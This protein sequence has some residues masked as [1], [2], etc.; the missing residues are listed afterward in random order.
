MASR[1]WAAA[2]VGAALSSV[3]LAPAIGFA[4]LVPDAFT[5][6]LVDGAVIF[7]MVLGIAA[8]GAILSRREA[9]RVGPWGVEIGCWP[10]R[11]RI[12]WSD[13][14]AIGHILPGSV[15]SPLFALVHYD[16]DSRVLVV[17]GDRKVDALRAAFAAARDSE[18]AEAPEPAMAD[19]PRARDGAVVLQSPSP[20]WL[21]VVTVASGAMAI[22]ALALAVGWPA[23]PDA[24]VP[25]FVGAAS[26]VP[27]LYLSATQAGYAIGARHD[28]V[29]VATDDGTSR[30]GTAIAFAKVPWAPP[31]AC[32]ESLRGGDAAMVLALRPRAA[33]QLP[34]L[35]DGNPR[36][37][38]RVMTGPALPGPW[39]QAL[40]LA[41]PPLLFTVA[42]AACMH[43]MTAQ[44]LSLDFPRGG[45]DATMACRL[46]TVLPPLA[47]AAAG[48]AS[49]V[50]A[51]RAR[52]AV[53]RVVQGAEH[54]TQAADGAA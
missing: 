51:R 1:R 18:L 42:F 34:F 3:L 38:L 4:D 19:D 23:R 44:A 50:I 45:P 26:M 5:W 33:G 25:L 7:A 11:R 22:A 35:A 54:Q 15:W 13:I 21:A 36:P 41:P 46:L 49:L 17:A 6:V 43:S 28:R 9:C 10:R 24:M 52:A 32:A 27:Y 40:M 47:V 53:V 30:C 2:L 8:A 37:G 48:A 39:A 16:A 20:T 31:V 14:S 12:A 29:A